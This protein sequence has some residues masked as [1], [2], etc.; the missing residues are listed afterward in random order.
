MESGDPWTPDRARSSGSGI[1]VRS[2][3]ES[4]PD[5]DCSWFHRLWKVLHCVFEILKWL[6]FLALNI[7]GKIFR[8]WIFEPWLLQQL[9]REIY[10]LHLFV[11][12]S[13]NFWLCTT[14]EHLKRINFYININI[15]IWS[16]LSTKGER[17]TFIEIPW[18]RL[19]ASKNWALRLIKPIK[20]S[21][22]WNMLD[23]RSKNKNFRVIS[24]RPDRK[25]GLNKITGSLW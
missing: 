18:Y 10:L 22:F 23:S 7:E 17:T 12:F 24:A 16:Q 9:L 6:E 20:V 19:I 4:I 25:N 5:L 1:Y 8:I 11:T 2:L 21:F 15:S 3:G 14:A 13:S